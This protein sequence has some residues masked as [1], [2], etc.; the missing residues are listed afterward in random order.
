[1]SVKHAI[2]RGLKLVSSMLMKLGC[3]K[4]G[5]QVAARVGEQHLR[6]SPGLSVGA[7]V[8]RSLGRYRYYRVSI[9]GLAAQ[10]RHQFLRRLLGGVGP[11]TR[12]TFLAF[13]IGLRLIEEQYKEDVQTITA[14]RE[15]QRVFYRKH[16]LHEKDPLK[17]YRSFGYKL[18]EY[19]IGPR[20]GKGSNAAV[21]GASM[22][23]NNSG[24]SDDKLDFLVKPGEVEQPSISTGIPEVQSRALCLPVKPQENCRCPLAV[25]MLW[26]VS[27]G[28]SSESIF[29]SM[30]QELVPAN[31]KALIEK[32]GSVDVYGNF[33]TPPKKLE[34]HPNV[35]QVLRAFTSDV[36]LLPDAKVEYPDV[37]PARLYPAGIGHNRTLF[38]VM[39]NY[40]G[41]LRQYLSGTLPD[42][43][44]AAMMILQLLEGVDHL[45]KQRIAHRDLKS[46]NILVELDAS[47]LPRLV[48][49]DFGC[50]LAEEAVGLKLPFTSWYVDRG[51]NSCLM[52][53]E[54]ATALPGPRVVI[55]Y[56][57]SDAWAVGAISYEIL[58][59]PNPFYMQRNKGLESRN[60]AEEHLPALPVSV[61]LNLRHVIRLL[62]C[63]NPKKRPSAR[64]A[65]NMLHLRLWGEDILNSGKLRVSEAVTWLLSQAA[66]TLLLN[67]M[68]HGNTVETELR[69]SFLA[70][71]DYEELKTAAAL[72]HAGKEG[73][74]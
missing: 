66:A 16:A 21:Y 65:A 14:C 39:K 1:M 11:G 59:Q 34:P 42:V 45:V 25:K 17:H 35:V 18:E 26:N 12:A 63:R 38:L 55:D 7:A 3:L 15:I 40:P 51:G 47:G 36:P 41:T 24:Q 43:R 37:L 60:Y 44:V 29:R 33:G 28:S 4:P 53:P 57:K 2:G 6:L 56:S 70:N 64:I 61:P 46:D 62:L 67:R 10:L 22:L 8:T 48:I 58:G 68:H 74:F 32:C 72:V 54:V 31:S 27:A 23:P 71:L 30:H 13:G 20:I 69:K 9:G 49:T 73:S 50:C 19:Q 52:A 5:I